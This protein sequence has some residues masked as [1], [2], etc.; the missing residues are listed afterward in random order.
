MHW[1][2]LKDDDLICS[3]SHDGDYCIDKKV[4]IKKANI[5][6]KKCYKVKPRIMYFTLDDVD[7][8]FEDAMINYFILKNLLLEKMYFDR[9]GDYFGQIEKSIRQSIKETCKLGNLVE[10]TSAVNKYAKDLK[11]YEREERIYFHEKNSDG[12][13]RAKNIIIDEGIIEELENESKQ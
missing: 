9:P 13:K 7:S 10:L 3:F 11:F 5:I 12:G 1:D 2:D 4:N 6:F 8:F